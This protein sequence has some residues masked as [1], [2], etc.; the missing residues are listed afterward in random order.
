M[1]VCLVATACSVSVSHGER[2]A[3][4]VSARAA[5]EGLL[6]HGATAWNRGDL[7][8]FVSD[9]TPDATFVT[10]RRVVRGQ[11]NIR[12]LYE[13]RFRPG[14]QRD[15]LRFEDLEVDTVAADQIAM[16]AYYVLLR[17]D[18]VTSRGPT[19]LLLRRVAGRWYIAHDHSS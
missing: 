15:S 3:S 8:A 11:A 13:A 5:A 16:I 1:A 4:P 6:A 9:Y 19:S 7:D 18:S 17:G 10:A 14:A 2:A 12:A